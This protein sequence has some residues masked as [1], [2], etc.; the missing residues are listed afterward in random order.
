[1]SGPRGGFGETMDRFD[2]ILKRFY[3]GSSSGPG[4]P[5]RGPPHGAQL[6]QSSLRSVLLR[7]EALEH[8]IDELSEAVRAV[9]ESSDL[10]RIAERLEEYAQK[11]DRLEQVASRLDRLEKVLSDLATAYNDVSTHDL[12]TR[13]DILQI[14]NTLAVMRHEIDDIFRVLLLLF[15]M[16]RFFEK[17]DQ[18]TP[19]Q[20]SKIEFSG[21]FAFIVG[22]RDIHIVD[23]NGNVY[24]YDPDRVPSWFA[25]LFGIP[26]IPTKMNGG[27]VNPGLPLRRWKRGKR[28][29]GEGTGA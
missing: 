4:G 22:S 26:P 29:G 25:K 16:G 7:L 8:R 3:S 27:Y 23:R 11:L 28:G 5:T 13:E 19:E 18:L 2:D 9:L 1:M 21:A 14:S 12:A 15:P 6:S 24:R 17:I 20:L 10:L